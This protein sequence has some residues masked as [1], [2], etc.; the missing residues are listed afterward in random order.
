[1]VNYVDDVLSILPRLSQLVSL[2][3]NIWYFTAKSTTF[4]SLLWAVQISCYICVALCSAELKSCF[5]RA[6][7]FISGITILSVINTFKYALPFFL[8]SSLLY[9]FV[10]YINFQTKKFVYPK[11]VM[12]HWRTHLWQSDNF[13]ITS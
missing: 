7:I 13:I 1:M 8:V 11:C 3:A 2:W 4:D 9:K 6:F 10:S 12:W 5:T